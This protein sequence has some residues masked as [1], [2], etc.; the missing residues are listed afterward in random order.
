LERLSIIIPAKNE[1]YLEKTIQGLLDNATGE[2]EIIVVL[3]GYM[4]S[5]TVVSKR[6]H[7]LYY[8]D[9]IGMRE[10]INAGMDETKGKYVMK[11]DAHCLIAKG[12]DTQLIKDHQANW[13][14]IPRR[15]NLDV[16]KWERGEKIVD[17]QHFIFPLKYSPPSLHGF[18]N[19]GSDLLIDESMT[20]QGSCWFM[21]KEWWD[22]MHFLKDERYGTLPAQ[23]A[24]YIGNTTWMNGG[25]VVV[26]K[27]TWYAH[28]HKDTA[29]GYY[30]SRGLQR[31]CYE[32]SYNHWVNEK[33]EGFIK[34]IEKFWPVQ[35]WPKEWKSKLWK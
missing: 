14:Q 3:D 23:E 27:N 20:F 24:T 10:A 22:K 8:K 13:V 18:K 1:P 11:I 4:P 5:D 29:R 31:Q 15:Y 16:K 32:F 30:L 33:K 26:N 12:F 17:Y 2:I 7:Y 28:W 6:V 19:D 35:G 25:R 9:S 21:T 34:L